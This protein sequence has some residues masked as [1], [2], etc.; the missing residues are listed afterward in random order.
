MRERKLH[1]NKDT[2]SDID[3][4]SDDDM[5][6]RLVTHNRDKMCLVRVVGP[7]ERI[8][9]T[10]YIKNCHPLNIDDWKK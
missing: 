2:V 7:Q 4:D 6:G 5:L 10:E 3:V 9:I 8:K 1:V